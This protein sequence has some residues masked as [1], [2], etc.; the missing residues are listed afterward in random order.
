MNIFTE[1]EPCSS[2]R[3]V[4]KQFNRAYPGIVVNV[5]WK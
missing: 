4:I 5:Y 2:C 1:L 3:S